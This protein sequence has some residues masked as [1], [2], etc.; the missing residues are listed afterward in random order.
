MKYKVKRNAKK[1]AD[2]NNRRLASLNL[3]SLKL[4]LVFDDGSQH[5]GDDDDGDETKRICGI[6]PLF[7]RNCIISAANL[8]PESASS[9]PLARPISELFIFL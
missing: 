3:P 2:L 5:F 8:C 4:L 6:T 9:K 7:A 1:K